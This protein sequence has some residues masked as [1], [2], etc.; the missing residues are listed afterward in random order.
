MPTINIPKTKE[1]LKWLVSWEQFDELFEAIDGLATAKK[2]NVFDT[3]LF[4]CVEEELNEDIDAQSLSKDQIKDVLNK[5][6]DKL[7]L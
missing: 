3:S 5:A 2:I 4:K 6:I 1:E 7:E